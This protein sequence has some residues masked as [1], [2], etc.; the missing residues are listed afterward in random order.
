MP[1]LPTV[2]A[3][4]SS[5]GLAC[6][7]AR[8]RLEGSGF[9]L[10]TNPHGRKLTQAEL[11][12]LLLSHRPMGLLAGTEPV[13]GSVLEA[14]ADF[15]RVVSRVGVGWDNVDRSMAARLGIPVLRTEGVLTDAVA[16]MTLGFMLNALRLLSLQDRDLR[17]GNW[18]KRMG[19]LLRAKTVGIIGFGAI[20]RRVGDLCAAFGARVLHCDPLPAPD[21]PGERCELDE[22]LTLADV[23]TLHVSGS[24]R[25]L[26]NAELD[27]CRPGAIL[28]NTARGELIDEH[29]LAER[30]ADGRLGHACLDV[31]EREP[32]QG[33]L[34]GLNNTTLT[35]HVGSYALEARADMER[36]AVENLLSAL[37]G[38]A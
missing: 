32:Y 7:E 5:F 37:R 29:A 18:K 12:E 35:P 26:G 17:A 9:A 24:E 11:R 33:P 23:V 31:Y 27:R 20:G 28:I 34:A 6:T 30:L 22:L 3:T 1:A 4:T 36:L 25:L 19:S 2:L 8:E 21:A 13:T 10:V 16:E 14:A 38:D 15:L